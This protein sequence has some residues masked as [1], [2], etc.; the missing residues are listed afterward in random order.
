MNPFELHPRL[1]ADTFR[2]AESGTSVLLL[3]NNALLP[4]F[5]LVPKTDQC[6]LHRLDQDLRR[7][8]RDETDRLAAFV[9]REFQPDKLNIATIGNLVE[10]LHI[11]VIAR[12]RTD[13]CWPAPVWGVPQRRDYAASEVERLRLRTLESLGEGFAPRLGI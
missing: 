6:E 1:S 10:Q 3:M 11:H 5:I 4:W 2:L 9:E 7:R 12:Y 8:V 13:H